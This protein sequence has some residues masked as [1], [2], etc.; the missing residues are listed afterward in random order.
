[1]KK[2]YVL[3]ATVLFVACVPGPKNKAAAEEETEK[4]N[5]L[6]ELLA[7]YNKA[8]ENAG[9]AIQRD[10]LWDQR[11][12][13]IVKLQDSL[14]VFH[15]IKGKIDGISTRDVNKS[16]VVD[17]TI[18]IEP[19]QYFTISLECQYIV[20][21]DSLAT[22]ELYNVIKKT[23]EHSTVYVDGAIALTSKGKAA[24]SP[25]CDKDLGFSYPRYYFNVSAFSKSPLPELS[26]NLR[27]A[28]IVWRKGFESILRNGKSKETDEN[29]AAFKKAT[30]LL[31]P[32][33]DAYMGRYVNA[34][35]LDLYRN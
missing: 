24:I 1:M 14:G 21:I 15:N 13:D 33:E 10:E 18:E 19:E 26:P 28:I 30:E 17:Y 11:D 29:I 34:C 20:L 4:Q 8:E 2:L 7:K 5:E 25:W 27:N 3:L 16:K 31:T 12:I 35:S 9:N 22:D 6:V 23:N 32:D